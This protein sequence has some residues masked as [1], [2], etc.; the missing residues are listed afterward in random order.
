MD[1]NTVQETVSATTNAVA[2][3]SK[4]MKKDKIIVGA[5]FAATVVVASVGTALMCKFYKNHAKK[6]D[7]AEVSEEK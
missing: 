5:L 6:K 7:S 1:E 2:T 3:T 4:V